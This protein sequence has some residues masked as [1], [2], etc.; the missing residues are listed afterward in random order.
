MNAPLAPTQG[1]TQQVINGGKIDSKGWELA[2]TLNPLR[3][4]RGLNWISRTSFYHVEGQVLALPVPAF[5]V[6]NSG[7]GAAFGHGEI[8]VGYSPT[9]VWGNLYHGNLAAGAPAGTFVDTVLGDATPKFT[10]Q[11]GNE[12]TWRALS[13][14]T[15]INVRKGGVVSNLTINLFDEGFNSWDYDKASPNTAIGATLGAWRYNSWHGTQNASVY[16]QDG[17]YVKLREITLSL[18]VPQKYF[19]LLLARGQCASARAVVT[20]TPG[21]TTGVSTP[22]RLSSAIS[23]CVSTSTSR[24][25]RRPRASS[26]ASTWGTDLHDSDSIT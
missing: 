10:M 4:S 25:I 11:Y 22:T 20:C 24:R 13:L 12:F 5:S 1:L 2:L 8:H 21:R 15:I 18:D 9:A 23:R 3:S 7:F 6:P 19:K 26:S 17:S 14:N 16:V